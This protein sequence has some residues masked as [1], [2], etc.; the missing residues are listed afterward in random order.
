MEFFSLK[1]IKTMLFPRSAGV[2]MHV[3]SLPSP[4]G[5]GDLGESAVRFI[6]FLVEAGQQIWQVLPLSPTI[7]CD[8]PYSSN[9]A[10]A[11]NPLLISPTELVK[12]GWLTRRELEGFGTLDASSRVDFP[13]VAAFKHRIL[14]AAFENFRASSVCEQIDDFEAFCTQ[15]QWWLRDFSLFAALIQ[16]YGHDNW[17]SWDPGLVHREI[18]ALGHWRETL[19]REIERQQFEQYLFDRQWKRL[20]EVAN[21]RGIRLFGDM[22]IFVSLGSADVWAHQDLF[23]LDRDGKPS[24]VAGVPPDYFSETGQL[25]GNP[26][27]RWDRLKETGYQWWI[28]RIGAAFRRCDLLRID[29]FRGFEAYWEV[30]A[31]AKT[32]VNGRW[33]PGPGAALFEAVQQRLGDLAIVAEDLGMIT[34]EVHRLRDRLGFP[35]MRVLQFGFDS[36]DDVFH[37]PESYPENSV[38][39]TGTHDNDTLLGWYQQRQKAKRQTATTDLLDHYLSADT[40]R[41]TVHWQL[42]TMVFNSA[43]HTAIVPMQD[44]LG[45]GNESRMNRPGTAHGNWGWRLLPEQLSDQAA[46]GLRVIAEHS[47]RLALV[48]AENSGIKN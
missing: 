33:V 48:H 14:T 8:S 11:G 16:H 27:Y 9:S 39:Y 28:Q 24:V 12:D 44:V 3:T 30:P 38:A 25:W 21:Q 23:Y 4:F 22:P 35:G 42:M 13:S 36:A 46:A 18:R 47:G 2:L 26:L 1:R 15:E 34:E 10:F 19:S 29:H 32:A 20:K 6:D 7:Q 37:R 17:R 43:S 41:D 31:E 5:I 45:L 40:T